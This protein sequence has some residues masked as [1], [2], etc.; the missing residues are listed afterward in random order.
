MNKLIQ[1]LVI[2]EKLTQD[3]LVSLALELSLNDSDPELKARFYSELL[4]KASRQ[5]LK[6]NIWLAYL[7]D[8]LLSDDNFFTRLAA[9]AKSIS[10]AISNSVLRE[11]AQIQALAQMELPD[12]GSYRE[13][14]REFTPPGAKIYGK[15]YRQ[16]LDKHHQLLAQGPPEELYLFLVNFHKTWG[17]GMLCRY[18]FFNWKGELSGIALEDNIQL[19]HL[20]NCNSQKQEVLAN[21]KAFMAHKKANNLLLYGERGTGKSSLVKAVGNHFGREGLRIVNLPLGELAKMDKLLNRLSQSAQRF[22]V[23]LDDVS[24]DSGDKDYKYL[25]SYIEGGLAVLPENTILYA[26]SNRRHLIAESWQDRQG[27]DEAM[28]LTDTVAEK[29]ALAER[30]GVTITFLAP[31]QES[32]LAIVE[33]IARNEGLK[34]ETKELRRQALLWE[35]WQNGRSGRTARQFINSLLGKDGD[36]PDNPPDSNPQ[37]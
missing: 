34:M 4:E 19:S 36:Q 9:G 8:K 20:I 23:F 16:I 11:L 15:Y 7:W 6:G 27:N 17:Y 28:Y 21:T 13:I 32:Y 22:I 33:G 30:F 3:K 5:S 31:D 35:R 1:N 24:F 26:T 2:Y 14:V 10:K 12:L 29:L 18:S 37:K 25:K